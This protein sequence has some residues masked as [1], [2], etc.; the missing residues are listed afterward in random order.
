MVLEATRL[1]YPNET[2]AEIFSQKLGYH[3]FW[4]IAKNVFGRG[5]SPILSLFNRPQVLY[6]TSDKE[7]IFEKRLLWDFE[8]RWLRIS[9][10]VFPSRT[11]PKLNKTH[12]TPN[13]VK[14]ILTKFALSKVFGPDCDLAVILQKFE[15]KNSYILRKLF[16]VYVVELRGF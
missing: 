11:N 6:C 3:N 16:N 4:R 7:K 9:L 2:K 5:K 1:I 10:L 8:S 13:L 15:L 12:I 14:K